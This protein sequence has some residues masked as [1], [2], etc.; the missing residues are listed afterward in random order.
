MIRLWHIFVLGVLIFAYPQSR[1]SA[2]DVEN[3][4]IVSIQTGPRSMRSDLMIVRKGGEYSADHHRYSRSQ[5]QRLVEAVT[6]PPV[7]RLDL[8]ALGVTQKWLDANAELALKKWKQSSKDGPSIDDVRFLENFKDLKKVRMLLHNYYQEKWKDDYPELNVI[9]SLQGGEEI[10]ARSTSQHLTMIPWVVQ[11]D[12]QRFE[13]FNPRIS[14]ALVDLLPWTFATN[15]DRLSGD[16][17]QLIA[18]RLFPPPPIN[19]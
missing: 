18:R 19:N 3:I 11:H 2:A 5:I 13:T 8:K 1:S 6:A 7:Q 9:I 16:L 17:A 10:I 14:A 4:R 12:G 15:R